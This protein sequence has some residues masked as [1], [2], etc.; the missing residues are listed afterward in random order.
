MPESTKIPGKTPEFGKFYLVDYE[1]V[2][3]FSFLQ[4]VL[5]GFPTTH[6]LIIVAGSQRNIHIFKDNVRCKSL[7]M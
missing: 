5:P 7:W 6:I 1:K 2:E 4:D 3:E